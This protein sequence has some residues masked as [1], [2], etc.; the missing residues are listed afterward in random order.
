M[1]RLQTCV[2]SWAINHF[3]QKFPAEPKWPTLFVFQKS[4]KMSSSELS[5]QC[6]QTDDG[7]WMMNSAKTISCGRWVWGGGRSVVLLI[8]RNLQFSQTRFSSFCSSHLDFF[9]FVLFL[10]VSLLAKLLLI[11]I[12]VCIR[13]FFFSPEALKLY[14]FLQTILRFFWNTVLCNWGQNK[15]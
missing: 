4:P 3:S 12:Y 2:G 1:H 13:I 5:T 15:I 7:C 6:K 8:Y 9:F 10:N 11:N 14:W